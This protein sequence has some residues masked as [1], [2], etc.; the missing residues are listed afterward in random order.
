MN[1]SAVLAGAVAQEGHG[2]S[3]RSAGPTLALIVGALV[4]GV[5][6]AVGLVLLHKGWLRRRSVVAGFFAAVLA[7][8]VLAGSAMLPATAP[9]ASAVAA[10]GVPVYDTL[11]LGSAHVPVLV[12]PNRPGLNLVSVTTTGRAAAGTDRDRLTAGRKAVGGAQTWIQVRLP[13]GRSSLWVSAGGSLGSLTVD[14]GQGT[15]GGTPSA[16]RG[17]DG[18]EC[19][20]SALGVLAAGVSRPLARCPADRLTGRDADA[21]RATVRYITG[22]GVRTLALAGDGSARGRAAAAVVRQ[23]A[24]RAGVAVTEPGARRLPLVLVAGWAGAYTSLT[25]AASG[26]VATEG[27]YLAPWLLDAPL[28]APAAGQLVALRYAPHDPAPMR[29]VSAL[30]RQFPGEEPT[31]AGYAAWQ[32]ARHSAD[33]APVLLYAAATARIPGTVAGSGHD[34]SSV[35]DWFP[36]GMIIPVTQPLDRS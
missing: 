21:L 23:A 1:G 12:V 28:L 13:A 22:R 3:G 31:A 9:V 33:T 27:T 17:P 29:Y 24:A 14:T 16:L 25:D 32:E 11:H 4:V 20:S 10:P 7:G 34:H 19:A 15:D 30:S 6:V 18:P 8:A 2:L 5:G 36:D 35:T 26:R